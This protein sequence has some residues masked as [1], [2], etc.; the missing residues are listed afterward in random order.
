MDK[1]PVGLVLVM[2]TPEGGRGAGMWMDQPAHRW[3]AGG[4]R[5]PG[6]VD[7]GQRPSPPGVG[8]VGFPAGLRRPNVCREQPRRTGLPADPRVGPIGLI[9]EWAHDLDHHLNTEGPKAFQESQPTLLI[10][11]WSD[12]FTIRKQDLEVNGP[13]TPENHWFV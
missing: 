9:F 13:I 1:N 7:R 12:L 4:C 10:S 6:L 5:R 3:T 2:R 8:I 11:F